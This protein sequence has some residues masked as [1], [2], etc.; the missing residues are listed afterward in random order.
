LLQSSTAVQV[1]VITFSCG[2]VPASMLSLRLT[3]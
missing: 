3:V 1:R 2:Q